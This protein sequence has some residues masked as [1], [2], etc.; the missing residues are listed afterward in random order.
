[1]NSAQPFWRWAALRSASSSVWRIIA[2][3]GRPVSELKRARREIS[4]SDRRCSVRSVPM[5][6]KPR[7]RPRSSKIGLPDSDQWTSSLAGR[8]HDD[9][10]EGE[11]R[12]QVEAERLALLERVRRLVDRQQ[13]GELAAEQRLGLALE[14][15]GELLRD[16][17]QGAE[18]VGFP[19]PAAAA[20]LELVD[21]VE[22][23]L[24]LP[25]DSQ[26]AAARR[27]R[28]CG[29]RD[30]VGDHHQR[31]RVDREGDRADCCEKSDVATNATTA[32]T[33]ASGGEAT[34]TI[35]RTKKPVAIASVT[36]AASR[37]C[38]TL[39]RRRRASTSS[40]CAPM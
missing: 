32:L 21:E 31:H 29:V 35:E 34:A 40:R 8:A 24:R 38:R 15:V 36:N 2:R 16:V 13:V 25:F 7:K 14:I 11:A 33:I 28:F 20:V 19:E 17:G 10:G 1:M 9:V 18:R 5:P 12:R 3:L 39:R 30:A 4:R 23:L 37:P 27:Q 6:R 22:R 26:P